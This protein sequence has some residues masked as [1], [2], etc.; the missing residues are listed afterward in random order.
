M[1]EVITIWGIV[2]FAQVGMWSSQ[3]GA[4]RKRGCGG[5]MI[6]ATGTSRL[7]R[8]NR[9]A[10][11]ASCRSEFSG[12]AGVVG[13]RIW[14]LFR[15]GPWPT[16]F[17]TAEENGSNKIMSRSQ[18]SAA[19]RISSHVLAVSLVGLMPISP[20]LPIVLALFSSGL[21]SVDCLTDGH[22]FWCCFVCWFSGRACTGGS[23]DVVCDL[24]SS[25]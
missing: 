24:W 4:I 17:Q 7:E 19:F 14:G 9:T 16:S 11:I 13:F 8:K 21:M 15:T 6:T 23:G 10:Q 1:S 3:H 22:F 2:S 25:R 18:T 20:I 12:N 5:S